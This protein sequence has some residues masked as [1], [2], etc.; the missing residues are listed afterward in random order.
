MMSPGPTPSDF[1]D[2]AFQHLPNSPLLVGVG[3]V[4]VSGRL[5]GRLA[6][7]QWA[8]RQAK[9][10]GYALPMYVRDDRNIDRAERMG[11]VVS[12]PDVGSILALG[13]TRSG[14][15]ETGKWIVDGMQ[16]D[17][18]EPMVVY[19]HKEDYQQFFDE[20]GREYITL[21]ASGSTHAWNVFVEIERESDAD[22]IARAIFAEI[23][24]AGGLSGAFFG[25][26]A[27]Q[28]F[29]AVLKY[30]CR[31]ADEDANLS[32][33]SVVGFFREHGP[34]E[35]YEAL[36]SDGKGDL[37]GVAA[38]INSDAGDTQQSGVWA[39]VQKHVTDVFTSDFARA[40]TD[41]RSSISIREYMENPED[42][43][44]VLDYPYREGSTTMPIFR[45][46]IDLAAR[47]ALVD[48]DRGSY[49]VLDEVAQIPDLQRLDEL[50]NVGAG[51]NIQVFIT[52]QSVAQLRA[53]YGEEEVSAILSGLTSTMLLRCDDP[54]SVEFIRAKIGREKTDHT[55]HVEKA[56]LPRGRQKTMHRERKPEHEHVFSE[57]E[58][59]NWRPGEGVVVRPD[60][61]THGC[62]RLYD[63]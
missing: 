20:I 42:K 3:A 22:E 5:S 62:V 18:N 13:A 37:V 50:V 55:A 27:R 25:P 16:A 2:L 59:N 15:T 54:K 12:I 30:L 46:L 9:R 11:S 43:A 24:Q 63:D 41:E 53:N 52:L 48:G 35:A 14:K 4:A 33:E 32:N 57:A 40:P 36:C 60:S 39:N 45:L 1:I 51:R 26:A 21:S 23:E 10:E 19:D 38:A 61:W 47:E 28:I 44:L 34:K 6:A 58:I 17:E 8:R 49:F 31:E 56:N 29:A 7:R